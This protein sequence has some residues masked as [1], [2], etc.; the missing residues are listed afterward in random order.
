MM[1]QL[2]C[3]KI[4]WDSLVSV[5]ISRFYAQRLLDG[6]LNHFAERQWGTKNTS[7]FKMGYKNFSNCAKL[8]STLVPRIDRDHY[9]KTNDKG[10]SAKLSSASLQNFANG[11]QFFVLFYTGFKDWNW[12]DSI[13]NLGGVLI[14]FTH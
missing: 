2:N 12:R 1:N 5:N 13:S 6:V 11:R 4:A 8:S 14:V 10:L 3:M 7:M 9:L